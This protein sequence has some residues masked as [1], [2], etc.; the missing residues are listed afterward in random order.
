MKKL[1]FLFSILTC[2]QVA[3]TS[4]NNDDDAPT[5]TPSRDRGE[6]ALA[7][8]A[9]I[10]TYLETHFY[11]YE[12]FETPS[13]DFDF[14]IRIDT[15]AGDNAGKIPLI[16]QVS[17][18]MVQDRIDEDVMYKLYFLR[19]LQ[20]EGDQPKFP[21]IVTL[22]YEGRLLE[23]NF[24]FDASNVP[25]QFDL[26]G[27]IN[28]FQDAI[29]EFNGAGDIGSNPDGSASFE[30]FGVGAVFLPSGLGYFAAGTAEIGSYEQLIFLFQIYAAETGDQDLDGVP[31]F[32]ED[33]N[34]NGLEEDDD[35][36]GDR[37]PNILD[38]DDD[39]DGRPTRDEIE[40]DDDG[41]ITFPDVDGDGIVDYLDS[42]S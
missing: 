36:D 4:C 33:L 5:I 3:V 37:L 26:T 7:A 23:N 13:A 42:D 11:N 40:I 20:G 15:L 19:V 14:R 27:T 41:N 22:S 28:G 32:M 21:D 17:S 8:E 25:T 1:L 9:E 38:N 12:E 2:I 30:N 16:E 29:I 24:L 39:G 10:V 31:S 34:G 18:K 35:T 6:E